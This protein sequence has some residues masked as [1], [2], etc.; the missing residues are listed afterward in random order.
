MRRHRKQ[1][2]ERKLRDI[3]YVDVNGDGEISFDDRTDIGDPIPAA[4]MG[5]N[6]QLNYKSLDFLYTVLHL[7]GMI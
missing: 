1:E 5:F 7:L 3:R 6:V 2:L 4:T